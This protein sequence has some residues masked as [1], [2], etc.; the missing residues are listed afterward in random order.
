[1]TARVPG[2]DNA[3]VDAV[4]AESSELRP[5]SR[6]FAGAKTTVDATLEPTP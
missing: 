6:L 3:G 1:M 5:V 4:T 2:L